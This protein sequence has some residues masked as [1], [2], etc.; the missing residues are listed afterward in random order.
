[1]RVWDGP[2]GKTISSFILNAVRGLIEDW[3][4]NKEAEEIMALNEPTVSW[5]EVHRKA[6]L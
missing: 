1:M 5:N 3:E 2:R 6:G 4:D